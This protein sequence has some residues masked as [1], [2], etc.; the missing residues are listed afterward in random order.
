MLCEGCTCAN[1]YAP[2]HNCHG[3]YKCNKGCEVFG[4][5]SNDH[6]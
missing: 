3:L 6:K 4:W 2:K 5:G 1:P